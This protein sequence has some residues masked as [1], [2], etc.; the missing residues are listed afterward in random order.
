MQSAAARAATHRSSRRSGSV[1]APRG[2]G[3]GAP[4]DAAVVAR[5]SIE[6]AV[7]QLDDDVE[8]GRRER[9]HDVFARQV[10]RGCFRVRR[11]IERGR[12]R[13]RG[14][15]R[16]ARRAVEAARRQPIELGIPD[17][18]RLPFG[19][20]L[21]FEVPVHPIAIDERDA[22]VDLEAERQAGWPIEVVFARDA[23]E[24]IDAVRAAPQPDGR[25]GIAVDVQ[26]KAPPRGAS[27]R[28]KSLRRDQ[29][30]NAIGGLARVPD[31]DVGPA[32]S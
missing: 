18:H 8:A 14:P 32:E 21:G 24:E 11:R 13:D 16:P 28:E 7:V 4:V 27:M 9:S 15:T 31:V 3:T 19:D 26:R 1:Q 20:D 23:V 30:P 25:P 17:E 12:P 29:V 22:I 5:V 6:R 2:P 10:Q